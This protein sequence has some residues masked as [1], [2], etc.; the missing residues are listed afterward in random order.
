MDSGF[1]GVAALAVL[2]LGR[3][4]SESHLLSNRPGEEATHGMRLPPGSFH[5]LLGCN[6][7]GPLQQVQHLGRLAAVARSPLSASFRRAGGLGFRG[8]FGRFLGSA[9]LL[10]PFALGGRD[11][12]ALFRNP[13]LFVGFRLFARR[14]LGSARFFSCHLRFSF[15][16]DYRVHDMDHSGAPGKQANSAAVGERR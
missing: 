11:V 10:G 15:G 4:D 16:G 12:G 5:Q 6:A 9:G 2:A 1:D 13:D 8:R 3:R 7:P 14:G